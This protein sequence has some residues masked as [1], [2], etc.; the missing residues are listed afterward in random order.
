MRVHVLFGGNSSFSFYRC[1]INSVMFSSVKI[2]FVEGSE[3]GVF[4]IYI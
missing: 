1:E 4:V 3:F 2:V